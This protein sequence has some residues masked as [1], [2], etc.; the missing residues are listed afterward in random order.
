MPYRQDGR[1]DEAR[2]AREQELEAKLE[3]ARLRVR[4]AAG[5]LRQLETRLDGERRDLEEGLAN[6]EDARRRAIH[7]S[8]VNDPRERGRLRDK[9]RTGGA[10]AALE[11]AMANRGR[12]KVAKSS[13]IEEA[14]AEMLRLRAR[15]ARLSARAEEALER[16]R[17]R[18]ADA[19]VEHD[20]VAREHEE[21]MARPR[22]D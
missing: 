13:S 10:V 20:A 8:L 18:L 9:M 1:T 2:E 5:A 19:V 15:R 14:Q 3:A 6:A 22:S 17:S 16:A 21:A 12:K 4:A 7:G 11:R